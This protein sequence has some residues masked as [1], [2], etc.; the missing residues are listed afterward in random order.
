MTQP[1]AFS[2]RARSAAAIAA[3]FAATAVA[4]CGAAQPVPIAPPR[5]VG[6][7]GL[8]VSPSSISMSPSQTTT[9]MASEKGYE[10]TFNETDDCSGVVTVEGTGGA[11]FTVTAVA[12]GTCTITIDDANGGSQHIAVSIQSVVIGGQ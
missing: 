1:F 10:G 12:D 3:C 9:I 6:S 2:I 4:G 8:V 5:Q 7:S 11:S